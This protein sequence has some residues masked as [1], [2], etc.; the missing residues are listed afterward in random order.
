MSFFFFFFLLGWLWLKW[1]VAEREREGYQNLLLGGG[2]GGPL[3]GNWVF[4]CHFLPLSIVGCAF[5]L[6]FRVAYFD[7]ASCCGEESEDGDVL[8]A[9]EEG[10]GDGNAGY[11]SGNLAWNMLQK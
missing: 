5:Y 3:G 8:E 6:T 7:R 9:C 11:G 2:W 1:F 10:F 4:I